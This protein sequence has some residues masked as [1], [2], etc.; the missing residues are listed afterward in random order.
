MAEDVPIERIDDSIALSLEPT[1]YSVP[2]LYD[3]PD[4]GENIA[5]TTDLATPDPA[6]EIIDQENISIAAVDATTLLQFTDFGQDDI[7]PWTPPANSFTQK[8]IA[9]TELS[10]QLNWQEPAAEHDDRSETTTN[11][12]SSKWPAPTIDQDRFISKKDNIELPKFPKKSE[13]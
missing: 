2:N 11:L 9:Q 3:R 5:T 10:P 8:A 1:A 13:D 6:R 4:V 7:P 12:P